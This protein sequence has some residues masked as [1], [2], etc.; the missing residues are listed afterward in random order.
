MYGKTARELAVEVLKEMEVAYNKRG[1]DKNA[2][3]L[4]DDVLKKMGSLEGGGEE[5]KKPVSVL[6]KLKVGS[7]KAAE[8]LDLVDRLKVIIKIL[9]EPPVVKI[10]APS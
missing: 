10:I 7:L 6:V 4:A 9:P 8:R 2:M 1:E 3:E 5:A